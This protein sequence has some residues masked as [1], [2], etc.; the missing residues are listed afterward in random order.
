MGHNMKPFDNFIEKMLESA[1]LVRAN[2]AGSATA[3]IQKALQDAGLL[4]G[5][6][7]AVPPAADAAAD[8]APAPEQGGTQP[9][10]DLNE[11]PSW[12][13]PR[14]AAGNAK[15]GA[16][17]RPKADAQA[18]AEAE[19]K[20][21]TPPLHDLG[22]DFKKAFK[23]RFKQPFVQPGGMPGMPGMPGTNAYVPDPA[24]PGDFIDGSYTCAAGTRRYKLYVPTTLASSEPPLVVMLHGCTQNPGDFATGTGMNAI[25]EKAGCLVLY[26]EQD[27]ASNHNV[28]WNWFDPGHQARDGGEPAI[29]AGMTR[30]IVAERGADPARVFA[31]GLSAGGA[32]AAILGATYPELFAAVGVHSGL[33]AGCAKDMISGLQAMKQPRRAATLGKAVPVIVFHGDGDHVVHPDNGEA[34]LRQVV[35]ARGGKPQERRERLAAGG[36]DVSKTTWVSGDG[37]KLAEHWVL[38]GAAHAWAGGNARGSHTDATGPNASEEMLRFFLA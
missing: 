25:A 28:C 2:D 7:G 29:I 10:I 38:H 9:F 18:D 32:M 1:R 21:T 34:V 33:P 5:Q 8:A 15:A 26:P 31:A 4:A 20:P 12:S 22:K 17:S 16:K 36:R 30:Q 35:A 23:S 14:R 27:R 3:L 6:A 11:V 19:V 37:G 13:M 24:A